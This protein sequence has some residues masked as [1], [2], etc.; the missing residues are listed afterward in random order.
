P[1]PALGWANTA[2]TSLLFE[3]INLLEYSPLD[4]G[5]KTM[6]WQQALGH[7]GN[8][9]RVVCIR[10][11]DPDLQSEFSHARSECPFSEQYPENC[12]SLANPP[13]HQHCKSK[14]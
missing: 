6:I 9:D 10:V 8:E 11:A 1:M 13:A 5:A 4:P 12:F 14:P 3:L 7:I 2:E